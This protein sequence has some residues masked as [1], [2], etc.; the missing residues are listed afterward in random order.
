MLTSGVL[1]ATTFLFLSSLA[2]SPAYSLY[3][4]E[5]FVGEGGSVFDY[6]LKKRILKTRNAIR[7]LEVSEFPA[8]IINSANTYLDIEQASAL[9]SDEAAQR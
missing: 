3:H 7:L 2:I 8:E 9:A 4:F 6:K 1:A 5:E